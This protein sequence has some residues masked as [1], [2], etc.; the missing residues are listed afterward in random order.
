MAWWNPE[1]WWKAVDNQYHSVDKAVKR[2]IHDAIKDVLDVV[3]S[4]VHDVERWA[5]DVLNR[6]GAVITN[7]GHLAQDA[8]NIGAHL[9]STIGGDIRSEATRLI[10]D[11]VGWVKGAIEEVTRAINE[12]IRWID[13]ADNWLVAWI[14]PWWSS[15]WDAV[16]AGPIHAIDTV[17]DLITHMFSDLWGGVYRDIIH[18]IETDLATAR[19]DLADLL[20]W[21]F[22]TAKDAIDGVIKAWDWIVYAGE[23]T[24]KEVEQLPGEIKLDLSTWDVSTMVE[25]GLSAVESVISAA[26][27]EH[28]GGG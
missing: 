3:H 12:A 16:L 21:Y 15:V 28:Y 11:A 27:A 19:K 4:A 1:S 22:H 20:D 24:I 14:R 17:A 7:V 18:P 10:T 13:N 23:H 2:L 5:T 25:D 6:F 9:A 26:T 8:Y